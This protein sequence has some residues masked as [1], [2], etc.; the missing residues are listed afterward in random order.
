MD[1]KKDTHLVLKYKDIEKYCSAG[2]LNALDFIRHKIKKGRE[3]DGRSVCNEYYMCNTDEPYANEV[4]KVIKNGE[5]KKNRTKKRVLLNR[6][7]DPKLSELEYV[8]VG[9]YVYA[10]ASAEEYG[11]TKNK[12]YEIIDTNG[13]DAVLVMT[14]KGTKQWFSVEY[15]RNNSTL[16]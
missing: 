11:L 6:F 13:F 2:D 4:L 3:K 1:I 10:T 15:F 5:D 16:N 7:D 12:L 8:D 9:N 14:D